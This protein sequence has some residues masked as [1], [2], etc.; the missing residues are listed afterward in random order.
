MLTQAQIDQFKIRAKQAGYSDL[1][2]E[3]EVIRKNAEQS[4]QNQVQNQSAPPATAGVSSSPATTAPEKDGFVKSFL[5]AIIKPA[6]EGLKMADLM[7]SALTGEQYYK[8]PNYYQNAPDA[9]KKLRYSPEELE[10]KF[11]GKT[12]GGRIANTFKTTLKTSAGVGSYLVPMGVGTKGILAAGAAAGGLSAV[13]EDKSTLGSVA[14]G[15]GMGA[16]GGY[17]FGDLLPKGIKGIGSKIKGGS[18]KIA[19][20]SISPSPTQ[21][22]IFKQVAGESVEDFA[23]ARGLL[24][25]DPNLVQKTIDPLQDAFDDIALRS[26]NTGSVLNVLDKFGPVIQK[27]AN[28]TSEDDKMVARRLTKTAENFI[29]KYGDD[30]IDVSDFTKER[31]VFDK[32]LNSKDFSAVQT[33]AA[34]EA[35]KEARFALQGIVED[36]TKGEKL[37]DGRNLADLGQELKKLYSFREIIEQQAGKGK[38]TSIPFGLLSGGA[39]GLAGLGMSLED[40]KEGD[41]AAAAM[42]IALGI[43][44]TRLAN[45][46]KVLTKISKALEKFGQKLAET[47]QGS[48]PQQVGGR[49][50][51]IGAASVLGNKGIEQTQTESKNEDENTDLNNLDHNPSLPQEKDIFNGMSKQEVLSLATSQGAGKAELE[52]ISGVYDLLTKQST[53]PTEFI[54]RSEP[55]TGYTLD[56]LEQGMLNALADG[57]GEAYQTISKM[58]SIVESREKRM[59]TAGKP[60]SGKASAKDVATAKSGLDSLAKLETIIKDHPTKLWKKPLPGAAGARDLDAAAR[61]VLDAIARLR[62]GAAMTEKEEEFYWKMLPSFLDSTEVQKQ[63]IEQLRFYMSQIANAEPVV[64]TGVQLAE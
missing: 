30:I 8:D 36:I 7:G 6:V 39:G 61:N 50:V 48:L 62:T 24:G 59:A 45:N 19:L 13:S 60:A 26:G 15:A 37:P 49:M 27:Y 44:A 2:I 64:D 46:P 56:Q 31:R 40:I 35:N 28:S 9:V 1:D 51:G 10:A 12:E 34:K 17:L 63:R 58:Y 14:L 55:T 43:G 52:E 20:S 21:Q 23:S 29:T 42:K 38:G 57:N 32:Y 54:Q 33:A 25:R 3:R 4:A 41:Y 16:A 47:P 5:K 22:R 53:T 11:G 18:K